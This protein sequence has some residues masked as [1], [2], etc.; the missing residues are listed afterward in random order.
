MERISDDRGLRKECAEYI[1]VII[2]HIDRNIVNF[3]SFFPWNAIKVRRKC[4][5]ISVF[6]NVDDH[7]IMKV[8]KYE[9]VLFSSFS[10]KVDLIDAKDLR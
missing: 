8:E 7:T 10:G 3:V 2:G 6:E 5:F 9:N 4:M 1:T